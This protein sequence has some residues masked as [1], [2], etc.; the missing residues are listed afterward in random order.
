MAAVPSGLTVIEPAPEHGAVWAPAF[1][2]Q[3]VRFLEHQDGLT[4][5]EKARLTTEALGILAACQE[6]EALGQRAVLAVGRI[7]SGKTLS[8][9]A[10]AALARDNDYALVIVLAGISKFLEAQTR[11]RLTKDF[12]LETEADACESWL[13]TSSSPL[14]AGV[15]QDIPRLLRS[16]EDW[17][18]DGRQDGEDAPPTVVLVALKHHGHI[19]AVADVLPRGTPVPSIII[20]DESDQASLNGRVLQSTRPATTTYRSISLLRSRLASHTYVQYTATPQANLLLA[21]VDTLAPDA[22]RLVTPGAAYVGNEDFFGPDRLVEVIPDDDAGVFE[23]DV[24]VTEPPDSLLQAFDYFVVSAALSRHEATLSARSPSPAPVSMLVHPARTVAEHSKAA[25]WIRAR[26]HALETFGNDALGEALAPALARAQERDAHAGVEV[27]DIVRDVRRTLQLLGVIVLNRS[28]DGWAGAPGEDIPWASKYAWIVVGGQ[29]VDR[30]LTLPG[31][32]V[33]Y[34]P[35]SPGRHADTVQ[36]RARWLGYKRDYLDRCRV[37]LTEDSTR[38]F[39]DYSEHEQ[40]MHAEIQRIVSSGDSLKEWRRRF[41]LDPAWRP[42]RANVISRPIHQRKLNQWEQFDSL[43]SG[44]APSTADSESFDRVLGAVRAMP[45]ML[46]DAHGHDLVGCTLRDAFEI[47]EG[48]PLLD[49][50]DAEDKKALL[51]EHI[52]RRIDAQGEDAEAAIYLMNGCDPD[53]P[54]KR[55]AVERD[56]KVEISALLQGRNAGYPGDREM[57]APGSA[58]TL[59][60]HL[61]QPTRERRSGPSFWPGG[62]TMLALAAYIAPGSDPGWVV[63]L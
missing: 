37:W 19:S 20:D 46:A 17:R 63:E 35:R 39:T 49:P 55:S 1:G 30:G 38:F 16:W 29:M 32:T 25:H 22:V 57:R 45:G 10:L 42:T 48:Y 24:H 43:G 18:R 14:L 36:Q 9:E 26:I 2:S 15:D 56:D 4:D 3:T 34:M 27:A 23:H 40:H 6:P 28:D 54:R 8:F 50:V 5:E 21:A 52:A 62:Q 41:L 47:V 11:R 60:L 61:V 53:R 58:L 13:L 31:L 33:T 51:L 7:Q 44:D 12:R 59:Q